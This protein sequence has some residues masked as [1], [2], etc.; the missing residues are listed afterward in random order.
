MSVH[1]PN[2]P[3]LILPLGE[4]TINGVQQEG[5]LY[6]V[7]LVACLLAM[8]VAAVVHIQWPLQ[9]RFGV[10]QRQGFSRPPPGLVIVPPT[11][12]PASRPARPPTVAPCRY[13]GAGSST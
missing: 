4:Q 6:H 8:V 9:S 3:I 1:I 7:A 13:A 5:V 2:R 11:R 10:Q 12:P